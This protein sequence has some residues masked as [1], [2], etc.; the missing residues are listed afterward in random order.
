M[1]IINHDYLA[2]SLNTN[3]TA[4][5]FDFS[6][7]LNRSNLH[8]TLD[9]QYLETS[10]KTMQIDIKAV[11]FLLTNALSDHI[12]RRMRFTLS[13]RDDRIQRVVVLL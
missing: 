3:N 4:I 9:S 10:E 12:E 7:V 6:L 11:N 13:S 8:L 2:T 5:I 1:F